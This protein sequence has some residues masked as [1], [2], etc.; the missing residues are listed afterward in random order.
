MADL[1]GFFID[2]L[3]LLEKYSMGKDADIDTLNFGAWTIINNTTQ[4]LAKFK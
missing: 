3:R 2:E 4:S 1:V